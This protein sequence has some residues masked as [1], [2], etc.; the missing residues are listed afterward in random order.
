MADEQEFW[1]Q[2]AADTASRRTH[3]LPDVGRPL[4]PPRLAS[5]FAER[6]REW[7]S[8][9][10]FGVV[11]LVIVALLLLRPVGVGP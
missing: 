11:L 10:R 7:R 2:I 3:P 9:A 1:D 4:R 6:L 5:G 8:D